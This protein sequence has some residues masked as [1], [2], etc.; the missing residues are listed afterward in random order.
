MLENANLLLLDE[1]TNHLDI[2]ARESLEDALSEYPGS[3]LFVSHD[4]R[5]ISDLA[6]ALWVVE[7]GRLKV[8]DGTFEEYLERSAVKDVPS[9]PAPP[10][11]QTA[12]PPASMSP[13]AAP[14]LTYKQQQALTNLE[15]NIET[16]EAT[17][18]HL[19]EQIHEASSRGDVRA[20]AD[21]GQQHDDLKAEIDALMEEWAELTV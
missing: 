20:L 8:F 1:P 6:T 18:A 9:T 5:L 16:K 14:K 21:L 10:K 4:R 19:V 17:L 2:P 3:I 11:Q 7:D 15:K 12:P 13:A